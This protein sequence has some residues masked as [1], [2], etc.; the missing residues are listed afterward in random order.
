MLGRFD[1]AS[2]ALCGIYAEHASWSLAR[3]LIANAYLERMMAEQAQKCAQDSADRFRSNQ[4]ILKDDSH[5]ETA[6]TAGAINE[7]AL[8]PSM[9]FVRNRH[10]ANGLHG[11]R[12]YRR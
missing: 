4:P 11:S 3:T 7:G 1:N 12:R 10:S 9:T 6:I 5:S 8:R 2:L